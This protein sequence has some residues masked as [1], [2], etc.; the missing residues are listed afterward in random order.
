MF[1]DQTGI[2]TNIFCYF[3]NFVVKLPNLHYHTILPYLYMRTNELKQETIFDG[4]VNSNKF[5]TH[6]HTLWCWLRVG[7]SREKRTRKD[8]GIIPENYGINAIISLN[9]RHAIIRS[10]T[11]ARHGQI[12]LH[13]V[14]LCFPKHFNSI[15][16]SNTSLLFSHNKVDPRSHRSC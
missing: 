16:L 14:L 3:P 6:T 15:S 8:T 9:S 7:I 12:I 2:K 13:A 11:S 4:W 5:F 1:H 10:A